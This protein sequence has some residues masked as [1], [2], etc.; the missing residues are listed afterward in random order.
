M[1]VNILIFIAVFAVLVL[2]HELGHFI[3]ARFFGMQVDE[4]GVGFPPRLFSR[5]RGDTVYS[6][7]A[8]PLGGFVKIAGEDGSEENDMVSPETKRTGLTKN[9]FGSACWCFAVAWR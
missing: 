5:K 1:I 9:R 7:N 6:I 3:A 8:I 4:F 2:V